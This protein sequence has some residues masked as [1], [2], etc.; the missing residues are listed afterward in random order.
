M[1]TRAKQWYVANRVIDLF[2]SVDRSESEYFQS[3]DHWLRVYPQQ[4]IT[5][6]TDDDIYTT[7]HT[8]CLD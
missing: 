1:A 3:A 4:A 2:H 5:I 7:S 8:F 6:I